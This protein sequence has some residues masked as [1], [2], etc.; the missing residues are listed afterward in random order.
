MRLERWKGRAM[1]GMLSI[2]VFILEVM[3]KR[4]PV[5]SRMVRWLGSKSEAS[6]CLQS[7]GHFTPLVK[8]CHS[9]MQ[10]CVLILTEKKTYVQLPWFGLLYLTSHPVGPEIQSI[11]WKFSIF[12]SKYRGVLCFNW[13]RYL[14]GNPSILLIEAL[15]TLRVI[16]TFNKYLLYTCYMLGS[17]LGTRVQ[18]LTTY[19]LWLASWRRE[20]E[21]ASK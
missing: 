15:P 1:D 14:K 4:K 16:N 7:P 21:Q 2:L 17:D 13:S 11:L 20:T 12:T 8:T 18:W 9:G 19:A 6:F 10:G 5:S 3:R